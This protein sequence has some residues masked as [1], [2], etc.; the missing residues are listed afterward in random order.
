MRCKH[1]LELAAARELWMERFRSCGSQQQQ[2][3]LFCPTN[4]FA[5]ERAHRV[6]AAGLTHWD[7]FSIHG[8]APN[9][10]RE[11][12]HKQWFHSLITRLHRNNCPSGT[13]LEITFANSKWMSQKFKHQIVSCF[14]ICNGKLVWNQGSKFLSKMLGVWIF[15]AAFCKSIIYLM[16]KHP[17]KMTKKINFTLK[18][19]RP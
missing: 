14:E 17:I 3:M 16:L 9:S 6:A 7:P 1:R 13:Q 15:F 2:K 5:S 8:P 4:C 19:F 18:V 12:M 11:I 10:S